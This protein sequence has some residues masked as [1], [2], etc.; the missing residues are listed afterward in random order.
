MTA[1]CPHATSGSSV[2]CVVDDGLRHATAVLQRR[3]ARFAPPTPSALL[4]FAGLVLAT[5]SAAALGPVDVPETWG[6]SFA[7]R[8][9]LTGNWG[10]TRDALGQKGIVLDVDLLMTPQTVMSGGR[11]T[12]TV[13][14]GNA[15][16]TLNVDT[17]KAGWWP[18]GFFNVKGDSSFGNN[19][20]NEIGAVS[21]ANIL[22][23]V[24]DPIGTGSGLESATFTQFLSPKFG[25]TAGKIYMLDLAEHGEFYG[26][27]YDQ[28]MNASL[29]LPMATALMPLSAFGGGAIFLPTENLSVIA[30]ALDAS[31]SVMSNDIGDAFDDGVTMFGSASMKIAPAGLVGHQTVMGMWSD[32]SRL[33]LE[34]D[35]SNLARLLLTERYPRLGDPGPL[36]YRILE[37]R[38]PGLLV[39]VQ[40]ANR[41]NSSWFFSYGFDQYL[42]QPHGDAERGIGIFFNVGVSDGDPNP[43]EYNYM[44]GLGGNGVV[45]GRPHDTFGIGWARTQFSDELV[46]FLSQRLDLGLD[47]EDV[48]ELYYNVAVTPWLQL[49]PSIQ[50]IDAG[51]ERTLEES[52]RLEKLDTAAVFFLRTRVRF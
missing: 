31:G 45:P 17:G 27:I 3:G 19:G 52:G 28:F 40:P 33:S 49:S 36:L 41:E 32:K 13:A 48:V 37:N 4:V 47:H 20:R 1:M 34:Q 50:I 9:R 11:D 22:T 29:N 5:A 35:P 42:W 7:S 46:P 38:F 43:I 25:L 23:L 24:P 16:Y 26:N 6:G 30:L 12:G 14:W 39:P 8:E 21:P 2:P 10:G 18:G 44:V 51:L 15:V